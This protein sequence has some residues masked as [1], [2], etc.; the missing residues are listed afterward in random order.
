MQTWW[1]LDLGSRSG[2]LQVNDM[3]FLDG[4][5]KSNIYIWLDIKLIICWS[6]CQNLDFVHV[7]WRLRIETLQINCIRVLKDRGL[8]D[9]R[10]PCHCTWPLQSKSFSIW[11]FYS[12]HIFPWNREFLQICTLRNPVGRLAHADDIEVP[13]Q[14]PREVVDLMRRCRSEDPFARPCIELICDYLDQQFP[15]AAGVTP[16][17]YESSRDQSSQERVSYHTSLA[18]QWQVSEA[19]VLIG[20]MKWRLKRS[21]R[22]AS[23]AWWIHHRCQIPV[24]IL[25]R[26]FEQIT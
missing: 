2:K 8:K 1:R 24:P 13:S 7:T 19:F 4:T 18:L 14:A 6:A 16:L 10:Q 21:D 26:A 15:D 17:Q 20:R 11:A 3:F 5:S 9:L 23:D 22:W 25:L 12:H